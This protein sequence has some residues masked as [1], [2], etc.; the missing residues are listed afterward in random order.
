[1]TDDQIINSLINY[2]RDQGLN[3]VGILDNPIFTQLSTPTKVE[4][5]KKYAHALSSGGAGFTSKEMR[6]A[7]MGVA[8]SAAG[9]AVVGAASGFAAR[10]LKGTLGGAGWGLALG[11]G[12]LIGTAG[13]LA[14]SAYALYNARNHRRT[15]HDAVSA[16]GNS[17]TSDSSAKAIFDITPTAV[18]SVVK[19][20][21]DDAAKTLTDHIK[22]G[23]GE[24]L[25]QQLAEIA[26]IYN[27]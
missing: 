23:P 16:L 15:L 10:G 3:V 17:P 8:L 4:M 5:I 9:G 14:N 2:Y 22:K 20:M 27:T 11:G 25:K 6:D 1:M 19:D 24:T 7:K 18:T 13:G 21:R 26:A 12:A